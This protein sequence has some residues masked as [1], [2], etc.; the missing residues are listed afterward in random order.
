VALEHA[1]LPL[2]DAPVEGLEDRPEW[3]GLQRR[4]D[5]LL[6]PIAPG[7][8]A[9]ACLRRLLGV[10]RA[11]GV[12]VVLFRADASASARTDCTSGV[13]RATLHFDQP[14]AAGR[15]LA[16]GNLPFIGYEDL[17]FELA[18]LAART[19]LEE[20]HELLPVEEGDLLSAVRDYL[21]VPASEIRD[22]RHQ[23]ES[24]TAARHRIWCFNSLPLSVYGAHKRP[25]RKSVK[26][27]RRVDIP[28]YRKSTSISAA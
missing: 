18:T 7:M 12:E 28:S 4:L 9:P 3:R 13:R 24:K 2:T 8:D 11:L 26:A 19:F 15:K 22:L 20:T 27:R 16:A 6:K 23:G 17:W 10:M 5:A 1:E 25:G 14:E 21:M